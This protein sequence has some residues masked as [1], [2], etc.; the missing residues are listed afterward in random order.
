VAEVAPPTLSPAQVAPLE[1]LLKA[2]FQFVAF[3]QFA[4]YPGAEK[5]GFVCLLDLSGDAVRQF[6]SVGYHLG[7][8]IGVLIERDGGKAFVCKKESVTATPE[9]LQ[10]YESVKKELEELLSGNVKQ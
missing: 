3:E 1:R 6:G 8:G 2:G 9:L 7:D 5:N 4:R 10:T